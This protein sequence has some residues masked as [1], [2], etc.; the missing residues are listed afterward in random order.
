MTT[1]PRFR[2]RSVAAAVIALTLC[3]PLSLT[4]CASKY[5]AQT[6]AVNY[7][8]QCYQ[9]VADLRADEHSAGKAA[10]TGAVGGALLGALIG[11]LVTGRASG[12][13]IG[14]AAGAATGAVAG[15]I[16][17]KS[18]GKERDERIAA[19]LS[20]LDGESATMDR[21]TAAARVATKCYNGEFARN[22]AAVKAG[23]MDKLEF[24]RRYD[25]IRAGLEETSRIL[26]ST[27]TNM[28]EK[29]AQYRQVMTAEPKQATQPVAQSTRK[30]SN[31]RTNM[32]G[33]KR[34]VDEQIAAQARIV[35]AL[36][37]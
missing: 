5:G 33:A 21:A 17:G 2:T 10:G 13:L 19:H 27:G 29:D 9:P 36:E 15:D 14:A 34:E 6:T 4:G 8:P 35:A 22:V 18:Q 31:S 23:T 25:E 3:L 30:W 11:G 1:H 7:Y 20:Q 37:G 32:E 24:T 26:N 28:A 12:A 16:Y